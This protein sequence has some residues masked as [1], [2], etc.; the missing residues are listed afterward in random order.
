MFHDVRCEFC[1]KS[2]KNIE[3]GEAMRKKTQHINKYHGIKAKRL[4]DETKEYMGAYV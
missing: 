2:F 1:G 4:E 3:W